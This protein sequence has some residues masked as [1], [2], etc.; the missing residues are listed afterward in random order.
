MAFGIKSGLTSTM[1]TTKFFI[2]FAFAFV[3]FQ[4]SL[5]LPNSVGKSRII[6]GL[7]A[8][9]RSFS[10]QV[11]FRLKNKGTHHCSG[12][13]LNSWWIITANRCVSNYSIDELK[14]VYGS[15]RLND[16]RIT[17]EIA[18]KVSHPDYDPQFINNN[19]AL[20]MTKTEIYFIPGIVSPIHLLHR[21]WQIDE[22]VF[23]S[24]WGV[25]KVLSK[26]K[27]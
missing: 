3:L 27:F 9:W 7:H 17:N 16:T 14:V 10:Y 6:G 21:P 26:M 24:G 5:S 18:V 2:F 19:I 1:E 4:G 12:A 25:D 22:I 11:S 13:I 23:I 15:A 8:Q 20:V